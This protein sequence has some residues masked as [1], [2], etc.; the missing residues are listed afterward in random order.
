MHLMWQK[1]AETHLRAS[2]ISKLFRGCTPDPR[3]KGK[4]REAKESRWLGRRDGRGRIWELHWYCNTRRNSSCPGAR[5]HCS[6]Y[7]LA[8]KSVLRHCC[9]RGNKCLKSKLVFV[10]NRCQK[11]C[12]H[13]NISLRCMR[14]AVQPEPLLTDIF[15]FSE[16]C[17]G[18]DASGCQRFKK[19]APAQIMKCMWEWVEVMK[20]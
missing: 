3:W 2:T 18:L 11:I 15:C 12:F 5:H 10:C 4:G 19:F 1:C 7:A 14:Q 13:R 6:G 17:R 20:L 9:W 16:S 8:E